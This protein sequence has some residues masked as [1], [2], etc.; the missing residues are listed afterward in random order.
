MSLIYLVRHPQTAVDL[1]IPSREWVLSLEGEQQARHLARQ[2][3]WGQVDMLFTSDEPKST[4][5]V[6]TVAEQTGLPWAVRGCLGEL[7]RSAFQP[8]DI[9]AYRSAVARM[10]SSPHESI[11]GWEPRARAEERIVTC[12]QELVAQHDGSNLA[13]VSHGLILTIL[14]AHLAGMSSPFDF[15]RE[16]GFASVAVLDSAGWEMVTPFDNSFLAS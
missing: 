2:P 8:P 6:E 11:R 12:V 9:A 16:I 4:V 5:T 10:F 1:A 15:W 7:D 3:F 13:I 14:V